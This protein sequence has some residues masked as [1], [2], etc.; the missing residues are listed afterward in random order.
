MLA[1][2]EDAD[3]LRTVL[4]AA[5]GVRAEVVKHRTV[6]LRDNVRIHLDEVRDLGA[7]IEFEAIVEGDCDDATARAKL[8]RLTRVFGIK[9][10]QV[11]G[12]SYADL[13]A[14]SDRSHELDML[15]IG[16][17]PQTPP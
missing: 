17:D 12:E 7:F 3:Q 15:R 2:V 10:E 8:D 5:F 16:A 1:P 11:I 4:A 6:Y 14:S 9:P 13:L